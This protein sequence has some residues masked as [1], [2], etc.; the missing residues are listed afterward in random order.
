MATPDTQEARIQALDEATLQKGLD[1]FRSRLTQAEL[2]SL[3]TC[4]HCGLCADACHYHR[5][6]AVPENIPAAKLDLVMS[7]FKRH[8]TA[9]G[10]LLGRW[11]GARDLDQAMVRSWVDAV[12]GRC[13]LCGRCSLN[14]T[15][16]I[17]LPA[18][19]RAARGALSAMGLAPAGLRSTVDIAIQ[20]GNNMGISKEDWLD[21]LQWLEEELQGETGDP[22]ARIPVDK[23]GARV[24]LVVNPREP[25]FFPL[26]LL[27]SA[28]VFWA[29][30]EDWTLSSEGWDLTNYG[31]FSGEADLAGRMVRTTVEA[32]SRLG[33]QVVALGECG[34][35]YAAHRW[36]GPEWLQESYP[37]TQV[38]VLELL[39]Q[40]LD[41]GRIQV[42]PAVHKDRITLHDP[43]NLVRHGGISEPQ[44]RI[45]HRL[46]GDFVEMTPNR[47]EN[48]C[49]GGGGGKLTMS[50]YLDRRLKAGGVKADQ[51]RATG[52]KVL[53]VPC[54][55][56]ID[57][58]DE[59]N[60]HY[61]LGV[62]I[63][64]VT[65]MVAEALVPPAAP[66]C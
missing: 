56:C 24:L 54:H 63:K 3:N 53:V 20:T 55:N 4:V 42:D 2:S 10:R 59:L 39:E 30:R 34:H 44:R 64:N 62:R 65:E 7:V 18:V 52:A 16:G 14:C 8:F 49:C 9:S 29:A 15:V 22:E 23:P 12:F 31:L 47:A 36:E 46:S 57:Q 61:K 41:E 40:Y 6:E 28:K 60:K 1:V 25:K 32:A 33:V 17:N 45:L 38:S 58:L 66:T 37:F 35:G 26:Q 5:T 19:L 48:F 13:T 11:V 43:C 51:I 27:A 50:E 21:T